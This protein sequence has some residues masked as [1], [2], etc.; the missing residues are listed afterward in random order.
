MLC[1][2][3]S[4]RT[5]LQNAWHKYHDFL[6]TN[7]IHLA[8]KSGL[9]SG[10]PNT[11]CFSGILFSLFSLNLYPVLQYTTEQVLTI[12]VK[13]HFYLNRNQNRGGSRTAATSK[14]E[15]FVIIVNGFQQLTIITKSSTLD[16]TAVL[17]PPLQSS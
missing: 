7:F 1:A 2:I 12:F 3:I 10:K 6:D 5:F 8:F 17:D 4:L 16:V 14:V 9:L 15:F 13:L 11:G